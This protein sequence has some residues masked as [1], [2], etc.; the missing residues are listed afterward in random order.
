MNRSPLSLE[1]HRN[2]H[3]RTARWEILEA[4]SSFRR[5]FAPYSSWDF[6]SRQTSR[7]NACFSTTRAAP[8]PWSYDGSS[9]NTMISVLHHVR[10]ILLCCGFSKTMIPALLI[11]ESSS[12]DEEGNTLSKL[13]PACFCDG[14]LAVLEWRRRR[15]DVVEGGTWQ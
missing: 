5:S 13:V 1:Y 12:C 14:M 10:D 11:R 4:Q 7:R 15:R 9:K 3:P 8:A 2:V 6:H